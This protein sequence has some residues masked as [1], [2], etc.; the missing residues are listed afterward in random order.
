MD[1][2]NLFD[3]ALYGADNVILDT[4]GITVH[5]EMAGKMMPVTAVFDAPA[6]DVTLPKQSG[7][8]EDVAPTLFV[9]T[10]LVQLVRKKARVTV[11]HDDYWVVKVGPDDG[12]SCVVTLAQG[13]PGKPAESPS[14]W[15][16]KS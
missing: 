2:E 11:N 8:V 5:I 4:M 7:N 12:G 15:S 10:A 16:A 3:E 14:G 9:R 1:F 13:T 6:A